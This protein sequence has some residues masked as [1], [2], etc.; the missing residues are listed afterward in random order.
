MG[1]DS[2]EILMEI[3]KEFGIA[4]PDRDAE[5]LVTVGGVCEYLARRIGELRPAAARCEYQSTFYA[6]RRACVAEL[7]VS[8][9]AFRPDATLGDLYP[10]ADREQVNDWF[11]RLEPRCG[12]KLPRIAPSM[13]GFVLAAVASG[14]VAAVVVHPVVGMLM[15]FVLL[16]FASGVEARWSYPRLRSSSSI[17]EWLHMT[18]WLNRLPPVSATWSE[19]RIFGAVQRIFAEQLGIPRERIRPETHIIYDLHVD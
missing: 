1:L 19:H 10:T 9:G 18:L 7:G 4:I 8:R 14:G 15:A 6:M 17:R 5:Q 11:A 13:R 12:L 16:L 2:V 3:E